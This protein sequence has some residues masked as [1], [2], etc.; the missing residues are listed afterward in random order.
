[1][2][3]SHREPSTNLHALGPVNM[4][5][6][7]FQRNFVKGLTTR[8]P[9]LSKKIKNYL[10]KEQLIIYKKKRRDYMLNLW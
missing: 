9:Q 3:L 2:L 4:D 8:G 6:R 10:K 5:N 1:M 7:D